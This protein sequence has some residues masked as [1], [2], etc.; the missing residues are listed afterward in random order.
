MLSGK[1]IIKQ[2]KEGNII[3]SDFDE[4]RIN[5]NSYNLR[6]GCKLV[7][8][9]GQVDM[10]K[11]PMT[12]ETI[13]PTE[14]LVLYPGRFYLGYTMEHTE[15]DKFVPCLDGRSSVAR[16]G[17]AVHVTAGFGDV[18][19]KGQWTLEIVP[20]VPIRVYPGCEICQIYFQE[21]TGDNSIK[22]AGKYQNSS[23]AVASRMIRDFGG[24]EEKLF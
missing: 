4:S 1:E 15:T 16:L 13:I 19:F 18:G 3:I 14:G 8:Y 2:V 24:I 20:H 21:L 22:Y 10:K 7:E 12:R 9:V 17:L 11:Q 23:G 6:L 5:P